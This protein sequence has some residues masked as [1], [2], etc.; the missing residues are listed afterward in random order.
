MSFI[1][2]W[3]PILASAVLV[4]VTSAIVWMVLKWHNRDFRQTADEEAARQALRGNAPGWY[5][6][7]FCLDPADLKKP[8][9]QQK[10]IDGPLAYITVLPNGLP[11]MG[12]QLVASFVFYLFVGALCAYVLSL[13]AS[14]GGSYLD[15]FRI[16]CT[17]AWIAHG[18][19]YLQDSIWF[20]RPWSVT[21]K[22]LV[23]ALLYGL[24]TGGAFGW[25]A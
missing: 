16:T 25:L 15:V 4:F 12:G 21:I 23:D 1:I 5:L 18:V 24:V 7:P 17:V 20:G 8:D 9:I 19:A 10:Y 3:Q 11:K 22:N 14:V 6:L 13:S 2:Y